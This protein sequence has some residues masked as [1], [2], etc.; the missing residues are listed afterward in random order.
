MNEQFTTS[1]R[2]RLSAP[3]ATTDRRRNRRAR[4]VLLLIILV[5]IGGAVSYWYVTKDYI[6]TDD[7]FTDGHA[8]TVAPQVAGAVATLAVTDNQAVKAGDLLVQ[9][10]PS[11]FQAARD[12]ANG[13]LQV[14]EAKLASARVAVE[15]ARVTYPARLDAAKAQRLH[16]QAAAFKAEADARRQRSLPKQATT[17]QDIDTAEAA[18]RATAAQ[19][20]EADAMVRQ[21]DIVAQSIARA[22]TEVRQLEGEVALARARLEQADLDLSRTRIIAPQD[23][24]VTKR[25][26]EKG[27][28]VTPG[29][30]LMSLVTSDVW[31]TANFKES[32][33]DR[34][35]K[36]QKVNLRVDAYPELHLTGHVDSIQLG[37]GQRFSLFPPENATGNFVKIVQRVPVKIVIDSGM[38][39]H[40][41]LPLGLS[42]I[43]TI[44][45]K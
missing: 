40:H 2:P 19:V 33:L 29:Q 12:Q 8:V 45:L 15:E 21:A 36:G 16:A 26:V 37:S 9:I 5:A 43:P 27:N 10:D 30:A 20:A 25:N 3:L 4:W 14:A 22:E 34:M 35:S 28:Y 17:Q 32:Q 41:P 1:D 7:A 18:V 31:V 44:S 38:D 39:P 24:W 23:G 13:S 11:N 42:V 6:S